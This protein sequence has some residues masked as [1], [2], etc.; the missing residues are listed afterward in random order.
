MSTTELE[1]SYMLYFNSKNFTSNGHKKG[2]NKA[3]L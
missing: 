2:K 3:K 1:E